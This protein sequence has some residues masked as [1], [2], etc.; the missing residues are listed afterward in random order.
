MIEGVNLLSGINARTKSGTHRATCTTYALY[1]FTAAE[2]CEPRG[3]VLAF[4]LLER[5]TFS[6]ITQ[7]H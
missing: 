2:I 4:M 6:T 7:E 3:F 1:Y 5:F